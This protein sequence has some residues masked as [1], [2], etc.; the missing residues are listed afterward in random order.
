MV[1]WIYETIRSLPPAWV[2][3]T[4]KKIPHIVQWKTMTS[5]KINL[6]EGN[7]LQT[8]EPDAKES[9]KKYWFTVKNNMPRIPGW[10]H[11]IGIL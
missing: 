2:V 10:V 8:L 3:K 5:S 4:K 1:A 7:V 11:K 6:V 9:H